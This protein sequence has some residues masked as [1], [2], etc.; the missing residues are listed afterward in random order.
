MIVRGK[1][2][3]V[4]VK[5]G[6]VPRSVGPQLAAYRHLYEMTSHNRVHRRLC[7]QLTGDGYRIHEQKA[8]TDWSVFIYA[9]NIWRYIN[10]A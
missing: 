9:L 1:R 5:T 6:A 8:P 4:D 3:V 7:V 2:V 10:A